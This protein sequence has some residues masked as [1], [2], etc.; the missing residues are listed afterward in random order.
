M[1][2]ASHAD[3]CSRPESHAPCEAALLKRP[4]RTVHLTRIPRTS[5]CSGRRMACGGD[6][7]LLVAMIVQPGWTLRYE[8][9]RAWPVIA[10][11]GIVLVSAWLR[12]FSGPGRD[13][14]CDLGI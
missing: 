1:R 14:T 9:V 5:Q 11:I 2:I 10:L 13:R 3:P 4:T 12:P 6:R 8:R 7:A